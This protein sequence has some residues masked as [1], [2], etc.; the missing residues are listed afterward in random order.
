M[1]SRDASSGTTPPYASCISIWLCSACESSCGTS[2]APWQLIIATPVSSHDDSMPRSDI[3]E[4]YRYVSPG[5]AGRKARNTSRQPRT[6]PGFAGG[7]LFDSPEDG[8][9]CSRTVAP[10]GQ[11]PVG[12]H[13]RVQAHCMAGSVG[14]VPAHRL[15]THAQR[16]VASLRHRAA[17]VREQR[18]DQARGARVPPDA[19]RTRL[20]ARARSRGLARPARTAERLAA[21]RAA[22]RERD[23]L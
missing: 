10:G 19:E 12:T 17:A 14:A 7:P 16:H 3:G 2:A 11:P 18:S 21:P 23:A 22:W 5:L 1:W 20:A 8:Y 15:P 6:Y 9:S 4:V 13:E